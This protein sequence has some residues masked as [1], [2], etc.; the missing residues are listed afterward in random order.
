M[1]GFQGDSHESIYAGQLTNN[2]TI[3]LLHN[4]KTKCVNVHILLYLNLS[5]R[6]MLYIAQER[7]LWMKVTYGLERAN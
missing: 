5:E 4:I 3:S 2:N 7:S 6:F 1:A